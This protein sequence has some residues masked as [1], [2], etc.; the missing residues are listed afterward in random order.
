MKKSYLLLALAIFGFGGISAL[1]AQLDP[2]F[3]KCVKVLNGGNGR[4]LST[5]EDV[6]GIH[7]NPRVDGGA[8]S[9]S[10]FK[11]STIP[12]GYVST[13]T[14]Q[15]WFSK[16]YPNALCSEEYNN[17][18]SLIAAKFYLDFG[19][20]KNGV[21]VPHAIGSAF[22]GG[23]SLSFPHQYPTSESNNPRSQRYYYCM[24]GGYEYVTGNVNYSP[25][26]LSCRECTSMC[27]NCPE[28]TETET[29]PR[30]GRTKTITTFTHRYGPN[31]IYKNFKD[32]VLALAAP[33]REL[34]LRQYRRETRQWRFL[35][36]CQSSRHP[37]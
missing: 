6:G 27:T 26:A 29:D 36:N 24:E 4:F 23:S 7:F 9:I 19:Y 8:N 33:A 10:L 21:W 17:V 28:K 31:N 25:D 2:S 16:M 11:K 5:Y 32:N 13:S 12:T 1:H 20:D 35:G 37:L 18:E 22:T 30:T 15:G 3:L 14:A 34:F